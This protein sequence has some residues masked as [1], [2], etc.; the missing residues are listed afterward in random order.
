MNLR[1]LQTKLDTQEKCLAF[2]EKLRWPD[3]IRCMTCGCD[4]ISRIKSSSKKQTVRYI[5][6]CLEP[7]CRQ[8]FT[9]TSGT[10]MND[11]H[12][13]LLT[14]LSAIA[15]VTQAKKGISGYQL[16]RNLGLGSY[17]TAWYLLHR[18]RESM[19]PGS[20]S[21][22]SGVLEID[23]TYIG[24]K[25]KGQGVYTGKKSKTAVMGIIRR[26]GDLRFLGTGTPTVKGKFAEAFIK[27]NVSPN[28][29][30]VCTDESVLYP[31]ALAHIGERHQ[32]V[33]HSRREFARLGGI[34]TNS[35]ENAFSLLKRGII[36]NF[37]WVSVKHLNRYLGE[38]EF[39]FNRRHDPNLFTDTVKAVARKEAMPF[40][41]LTKN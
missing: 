17:K 13:P 29:E 37:H 36:G 2:I 27:E 40:A 7:T 41:E 33:V 14:W 24:G 4:R 10:I 6:E 25:K 35:I 9:V 38:F 26:D 11:T 32:T 39:R 22:M 19:K 12:L 5:F 15:L 30:M 8:Q 23:E 20:R 1:E 16:Q 31:L 18:I 21:P 28:A 3:G 34:H